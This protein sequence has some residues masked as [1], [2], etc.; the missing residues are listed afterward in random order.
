MRSEI[1][2]MYDNTVW[3]LVAPPIGVKPIANKWIFKRKTDMDGN[4]T[5]Y[6]VRQVAKCLKQILEVL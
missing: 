4:M 2:S 3:N 1:Q 6:K 5:I